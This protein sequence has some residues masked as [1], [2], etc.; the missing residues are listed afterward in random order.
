MPS[1]Y[2][3]PAVPA[4][5]PV[6]CASYLIGANLPPIYPNPLS[7]SNNQYPSSPIISPPP[8]F[9]P[10]SVSPPGALG[11]CPPPFPF[12]PFS[13]PLSLR[14]S[15]S[16]GLLESFFLP[17]RP[18]AAKS[19][20]QPSLQYSPHLAAKPNPEPPSHSP[21]R[22][23][24][25]PL[26]SQQSP[27]RL[28]RSTRRNTLHASRDTSP[29]SITSPYPHISRIPLDFFTPIFS[30]K[31]NPPN[32]QRKS[33]TFHHFCTN[34]RAKLTRKRAKALILRFCNVTTLTP[35]CYTLYA[36]FGPES[37]SY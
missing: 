33:A 16:A 7:V 28:G 8:R 13:F 5:Y 12:C 17:P 6:R 27:N 2:P 30:P 36:V 23:F 19:F 9:P 26:I 1:N 25:T 29:P 21:S 20:S 37:Y 11:A 22:L 15:V 35:L 31:I 24:N 4:V 10:P 14:L 18:R 32:K 3:H 34:S